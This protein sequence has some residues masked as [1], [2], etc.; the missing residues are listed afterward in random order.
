MKLKASLVLEDALLLIETGKQQYACAAIQDVE[1]SVRLDLGEE[2]SSNAMQIFSKF[3]PAR[4]KPQIKLYSPWWDK[5]SSERIEALK[6]AIET[7]KKR[8]D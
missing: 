1:T 3:M 6:K 4:V 2:V 5:G 8:G 7:A